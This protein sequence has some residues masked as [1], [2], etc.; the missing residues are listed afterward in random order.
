MEMNIVNMTP[1]AV[2]LVNQEGEVLKTFEPSGSS[3]RLSSKTVEVGKI[4][5]IRLTET[6]Y[7]NPEGLPEEK[8]RTWYIVSAMVKSALPCRHDLLV[9]AEQVR[10]D[11]GRIIGCRSLGI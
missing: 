5:E 8:D 1:H 2:V 3:V 9:P 4:G 7:G 6:V 10:D 11:A